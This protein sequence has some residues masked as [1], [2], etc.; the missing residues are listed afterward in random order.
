MKSFLKQGNGKFEL[1]ASLRTISKRQATH[2]FLES[3]QELTIYGGTPETPGLGLVIAGFEDGYG[4]VK[5][6]NG[7]VYNGYMK[8]GKKHGFGKLLCDDGEVY[9][10]E[11]VED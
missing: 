9:E 5:Y 4:T 11:W 8:D 3:A 6:K 7:H 2:K 1:T 10:G